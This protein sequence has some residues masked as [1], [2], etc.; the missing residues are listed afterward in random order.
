MRAYRHRRSGAFGAA[1][2]AVL[3]AASCSGGAGGASDAPTGPPVRGGTATIAVGS[4]PT[5][6][7]THVNPQDI[8]AAIGRN[9]LDS[10]VS[11][12][13]Q[14]VF[15]P[16]LASS[17]EVAP[18]LKS[19]TFKL[20]TDVKFTDGTPFDAASVKANFDHITA[21]TTKSQYAAGLLGGKA[22]A[23]TEVVDAATVRVSF[24]QP[25][26]PF[27]QA[28]GTAYLGFY[29]P[30]T[31]ET[32]ADRLC[33]GGSHLVGTGPFTFASYTKGRDLVLENNPDYNWAPETAGHQGP[34]YLDRLTYQFL[35]E[36]AVRVGTLTSGQ[37]DMASSIP[38]VNVKGVEGKS[39]FRVL[40]RDFAGALYG[41]FLNTTRAPF[42]DERVRKAVQLGID[43]D[44]NVTSVYFGQ[45]KR[46]WS[47]LGP[48]TPGYTATLDNS[49][50]YDPVAAGR[51]LDEAGWTGRDGDGYRTRDG[52]RLSL[53]WPMS[54]S[55]VREQRDILAQAIQA[56]LKKIGIEV[57]RPA[58]D[59]GS[60][61]TNVYKGDYHILDTS[62]ARFEPDILRTY[63][64]SAS[65]PS[66]G[67]QNA[68]W[69]SDPDVD[70]WTADAAATL[71]KPTRDRLY[72][73]TQA[74]V[75]EHAVTVPIY[76][77]TTLV[78]VADRLQGVEFDPNGWPLFGDAWTTRR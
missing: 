60:F 18:D 48:A 14:G 35:Q 47:P 68:A 43:I 55:I 12:D 13:A 40:R 75:V 29:S 30:K 45:Y 15:H 44:T 38:P 34:A 28:A 11:E 69:L 20:R 63:F 77:A 70:T 21:A 25:F 10:L 52:H 8:T 6:F 61:N 3:L 9:V 53:K 65:L 62:W 56:D 19:Y 59:L 50:P 78:G 27:L 46:A 67:G 26:A 72:A 17:W 66:S 32:A 31:L 7:D 42:D 33:A 54:P 64:N 49:W 73:Q 37:V 36:D 2:A 74:W 57:E 23:G 22:Y 16:W 51:L 71:D 39:G 76:A 5:C 41:L 4:E 24:H 58:S 1:L